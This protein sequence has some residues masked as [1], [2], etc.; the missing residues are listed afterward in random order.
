MLP[1]STESFIENRADTETGSYF[2]GSLIGSKEGCWWM[3]VSRRLY[4]AETETHQR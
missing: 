4:L 1:V 2:C 3:V